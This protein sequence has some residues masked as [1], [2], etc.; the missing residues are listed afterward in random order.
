MRVGVTGATGFVGQRLVSRLIAGVHEPIPLVRRRTG[1]AGEVV[2]GDLTCAD[3]ATEVPRLDAYVHLAARTHVGRD[4]A[5]GGAAFHRVNVEGTRAALGLA[6][7]AGA[8]RF[9]LLS[10]VKVNGEQ[11]GAKPFRA[12][13]APAPK[14]DYG[15]SKLAAE[16]LVRD[17]CARAGMAWTVLRPPLVYGQGQKGNLALLDRLVRRRVPLPFGQVRNRRSMIHVDNLADLIVTAIEAPAAVDQVLMAG[18]GTVVGTRDLVQAI[19]AASHARPRLLPIP[20]SL[21][22]SAARLTGLRATLGRLM[23]DL[24]IDTVTTMNDLGWRPPFSPAD[25]LRITFAHTDDAG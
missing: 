7:R 8:G 1:L 15:R 14:D 25:A 4:D 22:R 11:S 24:E 19:A 20:L 3:L 23:E 10:S 12:V 9:V 2:I 5:E 17:V 18:D 16:E 6:A 21:L 13:D